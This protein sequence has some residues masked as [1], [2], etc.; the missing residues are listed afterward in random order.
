M[1]MTTV[2]LSNPAFAALSQDRQLRMACNDFIGSVMFGQMLKQ[3]RNSSLN[4]GLFSGKGEKVWQAQLDDALLQ[5]AAASPNGAGMFG[6]L[7]DA[8]YRSLGGR[9]AGATR[10][11]DVEG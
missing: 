7:G 2:Q 6:D 1:G 3:A 8:L 9:H 10:S 4:S 11:L 5:Q